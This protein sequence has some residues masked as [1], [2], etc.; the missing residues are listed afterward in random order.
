MTS[1]ERKQEEFGSVTQLLHEWAE[2]DRDALD[3]V[4]PMVYDE[5][6]RVAQN[7]FTTGSGNSFDLQ[8]TELVDLAYMKL[9]D[10]RNVRFE[11][12]KHFFW[13]ASQIIRRIII[14]QVRQRLAKKRG[15]GNLETLES[16]EVS[17]G[18]D[19]NHPDSA[20]LIALDTALSRLEEINPQH[21]R[22]VEMHS[23]AGMTIEEIANVMDTSAST[24]KREW[25]AAKRWLFFEL[26]RK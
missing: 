14:D 18:P 13:Y 16:E 6:R 19:L 15:G 8:A 1:E 9:R 22:I 12:R 25:R 24:I 17:P 10:S 23:F 5:L 26:T 3:R 20:T 4:L 2:G 7:Q 11:S 21:C